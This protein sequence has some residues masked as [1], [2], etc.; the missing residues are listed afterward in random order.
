MLP[1]AQPLSYGKSGCARDNDGPWDSDRTV[2]RKFMGCEVVTS[3]VTVR[4]PHG[5]APLR[6]VERQA[7]RRPIEG[8]AAPSP[9]H[10]HT[11]SL[12][13]NSCDPRC[14]ASKQQLGIPFSSSSHTMKRAA[15]P[16]TH[17]PKRQNRASES[18]RP[19]P[20]TTDA[21]QLTLRIS[22]IPGNVTKEGLHKALERL[23]ATPGTESPNVLAL[24]LAPHFVPS[25]SELIATATF[26]CVPL[27][28]A[29]NRVFQLHLGE[30]GNEVAHKIRVDRHFLG[31][32]PLSNPSIGPSVE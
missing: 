5:S 13:P 29:E 26:H 23:S 27:D 19:G 8:E 22:R 1:R 7:A 3:S 31:L 25:K 4:S 15:S 18:K 24:S 14:L 9:L 12:F 6:A 28:L 30:E 21:G 10:H 11:Q 32:T 16:L 17:D 20:A 2:V